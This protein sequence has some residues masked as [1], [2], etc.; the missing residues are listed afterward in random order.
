VYLHHA[1]IQLIAPID[2]RQKMTVAVLHP[3]ARSRLQA[4]CMCTT[5]DLPLGQ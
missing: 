1:G 4:T 3:A 5:M 2:L